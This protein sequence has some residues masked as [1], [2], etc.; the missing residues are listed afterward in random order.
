M[1]VMYFFT[2]ATNHQH[3]QLLMRNG[4]S[5]LQQYQTSTFIDLAQVYVSVVAVVVIVVVDV[6]AIVVAIAVLSKLPQTLLI[7]FNPGDE[8]FKNCSVG[9]GVGGVFL[10]LFPKKSSSKFQAFEKNRNIFVF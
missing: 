9:V 6:V 2:I 1:A 4:S 10:T 8:D 7:N 5:Q 3:N